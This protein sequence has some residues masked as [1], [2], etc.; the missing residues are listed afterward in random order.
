MDD[1]EFYSTII[2]VIDEVKS[3][4][5]LQDSDEYASAIFK[6]AEDWAERKR[7]EFIKGML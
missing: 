1:D 2:E 6:A 4:D 3:A 7:K 5:R